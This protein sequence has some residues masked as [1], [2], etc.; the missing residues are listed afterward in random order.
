MSEGR[1][2]LKRITNLL[3]YETAIPL[4][5]LPEYL[6]LI[7]QNRKAGKGRGGFGL[8]TPLGS[9]AVPS[10]KNRRHL[11]I[12]LPNADRDAARGFR[13]NLAQGWRL[14][15]LKW[16]PR[17]KLDLAAR[18]PWR[19]D[20]DHA[21][22]LLLNERTGMVQGI[23]ENP[24][25]ISLD[26]SPALVQW[27]VASGL[28]VLRLDQGGGLWTPRVELPSAF[29]APPFSFRL[30]QAKLETSADGL[31]L[32][33]LAEARV[34]VDLALGTHPVPGQYLKRVYQLSLELGPDGYPRARELRPFSSYRFNANHERLARVEVP[35]RPEP[36]T[37]AELEEIRE[38]NPQSPDAQYTLEDFQRA[39]EGVC[40]GFR[41]S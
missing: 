1:F 15:W 16:V 39:L 21:R 22:C 9:F 6:W 27:N 13:P 18:L 8:R 26:D 2:L 30:I 35:Y 3:E 12:F 34:Y 38:R 33:F 5:D 28:L 40:F 11:P 7:G 29:S 31:T 23:F 37:D 19:S 25:L 20:G 24:A 41:S 17:D 36:L 4:P 32:R 14:L 10:G